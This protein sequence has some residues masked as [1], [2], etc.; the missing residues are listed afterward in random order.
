[1]RLVRIVLAD[2]MS[3]L[4]FSAMRQLMMVEIAASAIYTSAQLGKAA[5]DRGVL[6]VMAKVPRHQFVPLELQPYAYG[7]F[8]LPI[9]FGKTI[10]QPFIVALM[11][12]LLEISQTDN[13]LEIGTGLG[14]QTAILAELAQRV[15]SVEIVDELAARARQKLTRYTN[16]EIRVGDGSAGW[17]EKAPFDKIIV[18]A[19]PELIPPPLIYQLKNGGRMVI[20]AGLAEAQQ[21]ML[22]T[23]DAS[24]S[25]STK[26]VIPVR[27]S[28]L[29]EA[30]AGDAR[31]T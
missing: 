23:K 31:A 5:L 17:A 11:T 21:L 27:F 20:P 15:Y 7:N 2:R 25:V 29:E 1:M 3:D 12:D 9:G 14:Y 24:G 26:N 28:R 22:V 8:P 16:V 4:D 10:S 19:A 18:T 13:V 6:D 30:E